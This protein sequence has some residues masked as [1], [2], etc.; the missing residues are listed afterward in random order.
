MRPMPS[1]SHWHLP[2]FYADFCWY[3]RWSPWVDWCWHHHYHPLLGPAADLVPAGG[4][5]RSRRRGSIMS[6]RS[7]SLCRRSLAARGWTCRRWPWSPAQFDL[8]LL[9]V[10]FVDPGHPDQKLGPRYRVWFRN[11]S[12]NRSPSRST[13][14]W[15]PRRDGQLQPNLAAGRGPRDRDRGRRHAVGGRPPADSR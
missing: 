13:C 15:W 10:R 12:A 2:Y 6:R 8:Q 11:N 9:A 1:S 14:S 3:P 5:H 4:L 7:G